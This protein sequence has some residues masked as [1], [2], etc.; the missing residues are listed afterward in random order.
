MYNKITPE[1]CRDLLFEEASA[2]RG[3]ENSLADIFERHGYREVI[4]PLLEFTD[5][6]SDFCG[7]R[8]NHE[9]YYRLTDCRGRLLAVRPESTAPIARLAATRL[10]D[11]A[12]PLKL[13]YSQT[14]LRSHPKTSGRDDEIVQSGIECIGTSESGENDAEIVSLAMLALASVSGERRHILE[15]GS[16]NA[17]RILISRLNFDEDTSETVRGLV[18]SKNVTELKKLLQN[19]TRGTAAG[20]PEIH[21][22]CLLPQLYGSVSD[23]PALFARLERLNI[24]GLADSVRPLLTLCRRVAATDCA[25]KVYVD[26][27]EVNRFDYYT[28]VVL[29]GYMAGCGMPVVTGGRYDGLVRRG[30]ETLPGMGFAV[31]VTAVLKSKP[32]PDSHKNTIKIAL[33]KGRLEK[34]ACELFKSRGFD[35][36]ALVDKGRRLLLPVTH[37]SG[38]TVEAVLAKPPDVIT[39]VTHGVCDLGLV[40]KDTILEYEDS[41]DFLEL[42]DFGWG[43]CRFALAGAAGRRD[44]FYGGYGVKVVATKYPE[45]ARQFC[46]ERGIPAELVKIEGSV[47]L[48]PL[49]GLSDA[50][51][52][53]VETGGTLSANG[54]A[55]YDDI[56]DISARLIGNVV[57]F[58][59]KSSAVSEILKIL[60]G[61]KN[62]ENIQPA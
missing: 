8:A 30:A 16:G 1:G 47:E 52:D 4:T 40:G 57:S 6:F 62:D 49:L 34:L 39:Y 53:I 17:L 42:H 61:D 48:A 3:I 44:D 25:G 15:L 7:T 33:T 46:D 27:G 45:V 37:P 35:V 19:L 29:T 51:V 50:I 59:L 23:A 38:I 13:R 12:L 20:I 56:C 54:L 32:A 2:R 36:S 11:A 18:A 21:A 5:V 10:K 22:L 43:A 41:G 58:K 31:N 24:P 28:G 26:F 9:N 60:L 14:M 55:V